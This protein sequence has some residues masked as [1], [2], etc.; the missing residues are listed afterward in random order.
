MRIIVI[1]ILT[2]A[3]YL[4]IKFFSDVNKQKD[5]LRKDGGL[6]KK[7]QT[8]L[9]YILA[10]DLQ[11]KVLRSTGDSIVA[12]VQNTGGSTLFILTQTFGSVTIQWKVDSPVFGKHTKEWEFTEDMDQDRIFDKIHKDLSEY[13]S[14]LINR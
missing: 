6:Q 10:S 8:L 1:I 5:T 7:Y 4:I 9:K 13:H 3:I 2:V 12:G 11:A 14:N